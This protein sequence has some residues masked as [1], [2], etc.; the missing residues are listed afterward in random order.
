ERLPRHLAC[1]LPG[2]QPA[3]LGVDQRQELPGGVRVT[4]LD[5]GQD[6]RD[7]AHAADCTSAGSETRPETSHPRH[8]ATGRSP[9]SWK[10]PA[11]GSAASWPATRIRTTTAPSAT[12]PSSS[13]SPAAPPP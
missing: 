6:T 1:Q 12:T 10:W 7:I 5:G 8:P 11:P 9:P 2:G 13:G 4:L 3:Q